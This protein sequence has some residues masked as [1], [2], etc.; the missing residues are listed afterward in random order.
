MEV[1][2]RDV[3]KI[4]VLTFFQIPRGTMRWIPSVIKV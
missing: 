3:H 4:D 1:V 2:G